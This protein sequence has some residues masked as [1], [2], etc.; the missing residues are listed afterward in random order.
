[1]RTLLSLLLTATGAIPAATLR[2]A[3]VEN[4]TGHPLARASILLEPVP[5]SSGVRMTG[6]TNRYGL[7]E[8]SSTA[9]GLYILQA[10]RVPFV[11]AYYGQKRWNSAGMPLN[12]TDSETQFV[13]IRMMR[14]AAIGGTVVDENDV[15]QPGIE[16]SAYRNTRPLQLIAH[17]AA[18]ERGVYRIYGL[19]PESY[20][21]RSMGKEIEGTGY[22]PTFAHET[23]SVDEARQVD[24]DV[25]QEAREVKLRAL[26]GQLFALTATVKTLLPMDVPVT[27][28]LV[29]EMG[30]QV[31]VTSKS[32][33]F[34]GLPRGD[35]EIFAEAPSETPGVKQGAYQRISLARNDV[36]DLVLRKM[37]PVRFDFAG[38]PLKAA[39]DG[40]VKLLGRRKD[41]AGSHDT[42]AIQLS[43]HYAALTVG[44]WEFAVVPIDGYYVSGFS[45]SSGYRNLKRFDGWNEQT[46]QSWGGFVRFSFSNSPAALHGTVTD[47]GDPAVGAPVFLEPV[48]LEPARRI[49]DTYVTIT[50]VHGRYNFGNLAPGHYRVLSSFEYQMPDSKIMTEARAREL[51]VDVRS[52]L[53]LDLDLYV[54]R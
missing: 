26:P 34:T 22:K 3:V 5:G 45:G 18:D 2:G 44:P 11:T 15:G 27:L 10:T 25:E 30:R 9:P 37:D 52:D 38:L 51:Q 39:D 32:H 29:S 28:T 46:I 43:D 21:V 42:Q 12:V 13:T 19:L 35:Y 7:F 47:T 8:F 50:D 41:L 16:V 6:H 20:L 4:L 36:V 53:G 33:I 40:T 49:T 1:M 17:A 54:I 24:V 14:F 48:D 23:E 31:A